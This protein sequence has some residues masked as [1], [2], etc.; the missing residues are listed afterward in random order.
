MS[1]KEIREL[2]GEL[3]EVS[4][5]EAVADKDN[6]EGGDFADE[7]EDIEESEE[8]SIGDTM[9][10][11]G[12]VREKWSNESLEDVVDWEA[13]GDFEGEEDVGFSYEP[14]GGNGVGGLY[15]SSD[16]GDLYGSG[17]SDNLYNNKGTKD[18][19]DFYNVVGVSGGK[20]VGVVNYEVAGGRGKKKQRRG[21]KS[22][23][24][25]GTKR[26]KGVSLI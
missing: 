9:L 1:V 5:D 19:S 8:F 25:S 15:G 12:E 26:K 11:R 6:W 23:L 7:D 4:V 22:G 13:S 2:E 18:E 10:A 14:A 20:K 17:N 16:A 24:E 3:K 21:G